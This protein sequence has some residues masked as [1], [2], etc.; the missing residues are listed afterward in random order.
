MELG[1]LDILE[2]TTSLATA[3]KG[4]RGTVVCL[5]PIEGTGRLAPDEMERRLIEMGFIE[6]AGV[7]ILHEGPFGG[8]PIAV[9]VGSAT[10]ALRRRDA[11]AILTE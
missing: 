9:R 7:E 10:V 3:R 6:G 4:Y 5:L 2:R 8:D 1:R 11:L